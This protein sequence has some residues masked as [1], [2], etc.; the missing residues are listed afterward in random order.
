VKKYL[1]ALALLFAPLLFPSM[2]AAQCSGNFPA[3]QFC[4][5]P[6]GGLPGP[7]S[8]FTFTGDQLFQSGRP[9]CD[10][11]AEGAKGDG[12]TDDSAAFVKCVN[13][14]TSGTGVLGGTLYVPPAPGGVYCLY[15]GL[16]I[17]ANLPIAVTGNAYANTELSPCNHDVGLVTLNNAPH[18]IQFL[19][20]AG[21]N[22]VGTTHDTLTLGAN[23]T[24]CAVDRVDV[25]YGRH[26][27]NVAGT[28]IRISRING[29]FPLDDST[30]YTTGSFSCSA[31]K[32]DSGYPVQAVT[33][34]TNRSNWATS[35]SYSKGDV[36]VT[37]NGYVIQAAN[38][39]TSLGSG[40]GP[41]GTGS[42]I[43]PFGT[44][45][46]DN[47]TGS[48]PS[49]SAGVCWLLVN[50]NGAAAVHA[51]SGSSTVTLT[52]RTDL[53][54]AYS[55]SALLTGT[56]QTLVMS[57]SYM[58][59]YLYGLY[60]NSSV[61][62]VIAVGN[63]CSNMTNTAAA[64][65]YVRGGQ[66]IVNSNTIIGSPI[67]ILTDGGINYTFNNNQIFGA[68]V[69]AIE[70]GG[71]VQRVAAIGN[72]CGSSV[73][74]GT[75]AICIDIATNTTDYLTALGNQCEG[76]ST[77]IGN[78][79]NAGPHS[80]IESK[81]GILLTNLGFGTSGG[82]V[83]GT[84]T[85]DGASAGIVGEYIVSGAS[86]R[87]NLNVSPATVTITIAAPAVIS[88]T[89]N[90]YY[91][92]TATNHGCGSVVVFATN[93]ALPTGL[94]AA[95]P[96]YVTCDAAL[97]ANAFHVSSSVDNAIAGT[98]I[99]TTGTQSGTQ[100]ATNLEPLSSPSTVDFG[101]FSLTAGDWDVS[102]QIV[103]SPNSSTSVTIST[104]GISSGTALSG[105][106]YSLGSVRQAAEVPG[107]AYQIN[108]GVERISLS[109]TTT[110]YCGVASTFTVSTNSASGEC[111]ARRVR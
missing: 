44:Y 41:G 15:S 88:W 105:I 24:E 12:S 89:G 1:L 37:T 19:A 26:P 110:F 79:S 43:Q 29:S 94:S 42:A 100:T 83:L 75:D 40:T 38:A 9:W 33:P 80:L 82:G 59:A 56:A 47:V 55:Y 23:C 101:G 96:Y 14:L 18:S 90:P 65:F 8:N 20:L 13:Q 39:G 103:F 95:T 28:D 10:V 71:S 84:T 36:V 3:G 22:V 97:T 62:G 85:N 21:P 78:S 58:A 51:D 48:C 34:G 25:F 93:G 111:R 68:S 107:G 64:C 27:I 86:G 106:F 49:P 45:I 74:W 60:D 63:Q 87:P 2:A 16:S 57:N 102:G 108:A 91:N 99:T 4:G 67:G 46:T 81:P 104:G 32:L 11:Q 109:A 5:S 50:K 98:A 72:I 6:N 66:D 30:I 53:S 17:T 73:A 76:A 35:T 77:C 70:V 7:V 69:A 31:C 54:G 52:N 92:A 61:G